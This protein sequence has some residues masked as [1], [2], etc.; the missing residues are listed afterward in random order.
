MK[1]ALSLLLFAASMTPAAFPPHQ[2][3]ACPPDGCK[4]GPLLN[5]KACH[6]FVED[7]PPPTCWPCKPPPKPPLIWG[8]E[9]GNAQ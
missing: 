8:E 2:S 4:L 1:L 6:T 7:V 9:G 5:C 3:Q